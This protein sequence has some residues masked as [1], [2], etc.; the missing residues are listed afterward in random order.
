VPELQLAGP[1]ARLY[2]TANHLGITVLDG[3]AA[4]GRWP[5]ERIAAIA[6]FGEHIAL[7]H[8]LDEG[9]RTDVLAMAL[10][11]A[12]VMG[13]CPTGHP[14]EIFAPG[15]FVLISQTRVPGTASGPGRLATLLAR[16]CGRDTASAAFEYT[17]PALADPSPW[18]PWIRAANSGLRGIGDRDHRLRRLP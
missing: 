7:K 16:R 14:C 1:L 2:G 10:I 4:A 17:A 13:D 9:L 3:V 11:V 8:G 15:G 6:V 18:A 12:A 5:D